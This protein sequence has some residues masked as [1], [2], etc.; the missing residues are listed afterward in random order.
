[1]DTLSQLIAEYEALASSPEHKRDPAIAT[2][3]AALRSARAHESMALGSSVW[4]PVRKAL[5][6]D[7]HVCESELARAVLRYVAEHPD[8]PVAHEPPA[9]IGCL[10]DCPMALAWLSTKV[11]E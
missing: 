10:P 4:A 9:H 8:A 1:M 7:A 11:T 3:L 2:A 5:G 6:V